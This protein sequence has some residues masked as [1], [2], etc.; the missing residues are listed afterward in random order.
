MTCLIQRGT[1]GRRQPKMSPSFRRT[2]QWIVERSDAAGI[3]MQRS[4]RAE[5]QAAELSLRST[6]FVLSRE[7]DKRSYP[8]FCR[9]R[10]DSILRHFDDGIFLDI[11]FV[12]T[13]VVSACSRV[14]IHVMPDNSRTPRRRNK[15][16]EC[17]FSSLVGSQRCNQ[18]LTIKLRNIYSARHERCSLS[19][20]GSIIHQDKLWHDGRNQ[21]FRFT[22]ACRKTSARYAK[23]PT[24]GLIAIALFCAA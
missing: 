14:E 1:G 20:Y 18:S 7:E 15:L 16:R 19:N 6:R 4:P 23:P 24:F 22:P 10:I 11:F 17:T 13:P 8:W 2:T 9:V 3:P 21:G 12:V 5:R